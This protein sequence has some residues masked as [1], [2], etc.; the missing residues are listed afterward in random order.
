MDSRP[1]AHMDKRMRAADRM[2]PARKDSRDSSPDDNLGPK[3]SDTRPAEVVRKDNLRPA[4]R[5]DRAPAGRAAAGSGRTAR[6]TAEP[7]QRRR[8]RSSAAAAA[9]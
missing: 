6:R 8:Y 7:A 5:E 3:D 9:K 1:A 2:G 4:P